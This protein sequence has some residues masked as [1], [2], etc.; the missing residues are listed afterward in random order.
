[1]NAIGI[2]IGTTSICLGIYEE[3][4]GRL[5]E[6]RREKNNFLPDTFWQDPER[7]FHTVKRM[8]DD[9]ILNG[10][11]PS[12]IGISS[13]MHGILYVDKE[14]HGVSPYYTWKT[15][16]GNDTFGEETY[17][18]CLSRSTGYEMYSGYGSVTHFYLQQTGRIPAEAVRLANIGDYIAM[19]LCHAREPVMSPSIAASMG[20]FSLWDGG[21]DLGVLR[22]AG[23]DTSYY[24]KVKAGGV[25][26]GEYQGIP[27]T[28]AQGD[29]QA[30]FYGAIGEREEALGINVGTGSQVS[31][32]HTKLVPGTGAEIRPFT[33]KGFL[34]VMASLNG[35][36]VYERL[37][38]FV[39][40]TVL[41][42]TGAE[43]EVYE[44]L[45][46]AGLGVAATDL[47]ITPTLY[48]SRKCPAPGGRME[49]LLPENFTLGD[50]VRA[51]VTGMASE[52]FRM[53]E[54][55]PDTLKREKR[56]IVASG[57]GI[58]RNR[59]LR[60]E[61]ERIFGLPVRFRKIEEE[62]AAGAAMWALEER[63]KTLR[64]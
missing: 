41:A 16:T 7:I 24:P 56:E 52:L 54:Q 58:R 10:G 46:Q 21:F 28:C 45:E 44:K 63:R 3:E 25:M 57:N 27:V 5:G 15:E 6:V 19:R 2:D 39:K 61:V 50:V 43:T 38:E 32:F 48:G 12:V 62:A 29:N 42:V 26:T 9:L 64:D 35:G 30:S 33:E 59:L 60:Q 51:Y 8:L 23:I 49:G 31:L 11:K 4:S 40:D 1:M 22:K 17:A 13:Q 14:G 20:G 36:K 55:L 18:A 34:Y 47:R 53:Y 37:A